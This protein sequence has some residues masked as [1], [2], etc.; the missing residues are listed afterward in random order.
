MTGLLSLAFA[1][2][3][4]APVNP[5]GFALLPAWIARTLGDA[6]GSPHPVRLLRALQAGA[7]LTIGFAGTLV[8]AGLVVS[9]GARGLIQAAPGLGLGLGALLVLL[10]L[11][12]LAG[13]TITVR[14]PGL[15]G[16][17]TDALPPIL[18]QVGFGVGYALA[19]LACTFGVLLAVIAQAQAAADF[20]GLALVFGAYA[21]GSAT[22]LLTL[23]VVTA[24]AGTA[25]SRRAVT[26]ARFGPRATGALLLITGVYLAWYWY[27]AASSNQ[28][29]GTGGPSGLTRVSAV[30]SSWIQGHTTAFAV[31]SVVV[32]AGTT[33]FVLLRTG[34][35]REAV[36]KVRA[37]LERRSDGL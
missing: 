24:L 36:E 3:M 11:A 17:T 2:G 27:P 26:L 18:Q 16:R 32:L 8:V 19:S 20:A 9:A 33:G 10:G 1:A 35:P 31:V 25:I 30:V 15:S 28:F 4:V 22:V 21:A 34:R 29:A 13:R 5:C 37:R 7:A 6:S 12:M 23:S 14:M